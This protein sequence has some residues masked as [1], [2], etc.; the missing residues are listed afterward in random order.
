[1]SRRVFEQGS[2]YCAM[3]SFV[4][5][6]KGSLGVLGLWGVSGQSQS[7]RLAKPV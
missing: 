4:Q 7:D 5:I 1:M 3:A 2:L 6:L